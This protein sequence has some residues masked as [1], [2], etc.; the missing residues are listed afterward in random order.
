MSSTCGARAA[1]EVGNREMP[2]YRDGEDPA[3]AAWI[4]ARPVLVWTEIAILYCFR[5]RGTAW[6]DGQSGSARAQ[7][8]PQASSSA[9]PE[10]PPSLARLRHHSLLERNAQRPPEGGGHTAG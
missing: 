9:V 4:L 6:I 8:R 10:P 3:G 7:A 2:G 1:Q 5:R